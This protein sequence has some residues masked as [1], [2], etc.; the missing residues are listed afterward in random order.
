[1]D[2]GFSVTRPHNVC[3]RRERWKQL[4]VATPRLEFYETRKAPWNQ[5]RDITYNTGKSAVMLLLNPPI[6]KKLGMVRAQH[7]FWIIKDSWGFELTR[8]R[9]H[10]KMDHPRRGFGD[11]H[12][13][14]MR[15][16]RGQ[17]ED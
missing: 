6:R 11:L 15:G 3:R 10:I 8:P 5:K 1:M 12:H 9:I 17:V 13:N 2:Y 4:Y 7:P 16:Q 14:V